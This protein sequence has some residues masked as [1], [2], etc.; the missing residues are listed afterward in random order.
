MIKHRKTMADWASDGKTWLWYEGSR[1][2]LEG[3]KQEALTRY[4]GRIEVGLPEYLSERKSSPGWTSPVYYMAFVFSN[5]DDAMM[6][7]L[8][9][10]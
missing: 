2:A 9:V 7:K 3:V 10:A 8:S 1:D 5:K 4:A 6:F